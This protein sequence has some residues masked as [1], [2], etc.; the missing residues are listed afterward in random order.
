MKSLANYDETNPK[1][2]AL[3]GVLSQTNPNPGIPM[4]GYCSLSEDCVL[5]VC[6][7]DY[8]DKQVSSMWAL[9]ATWEWLGPE[10]KA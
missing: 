6:D 2:A 8:R 1:A 4:K 5:A 9:L 7:M 3:S 10:L